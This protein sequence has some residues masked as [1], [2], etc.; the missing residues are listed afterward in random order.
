MDLGSIDD[1]RKRIAE[2][3]DKLK[4]FVIKAKADFEE[5]QEKMKKEGK[6]AEETDGSAA[7]DPAFAKRFPTRLE[8]P[9]AVQIPSKRPRGHAW[10]QDWLRGA[11]G[12]RC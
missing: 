9:S 6:V 3:R 1:L 2:D 8:T 11:E 4:L 10:I 5:K 12:H 7:A